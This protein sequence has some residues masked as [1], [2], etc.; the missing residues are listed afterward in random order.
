MS[1]QQQI[2]G[3]AWAVGLRLSVAPAFWADFDRLLEP[4][5]SS[6]HGPQTS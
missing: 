2:T 5:L 3:G 6:A 4:R 1:E